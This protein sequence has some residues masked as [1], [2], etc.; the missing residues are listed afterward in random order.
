MIALKLIS[1]HNLSVEEKISAIKEIYKGYPKPLLFTT[2]VG[3]FLKII[4]SPPYSYNMDA[5][6]DL[7]FS[8]IFKGNYAP[9][10]HFMSADYVKKYHQNYIASVKKDG[11]FI[12]ETPLLDISASKIFYF[13]KYPVTEFH[14]PFKLVNC[15]GIMNGYFFHGTFRTLML[16]F[17][18]E[19]T[20]IKLIILSYPGNSKIIKFSKDHFDEWID[21]LNSDNDAITYELHLDRH[22]SPGTYASVSDLVGPEILEL[23]T[24]IPEFHIDWHVKFTG[25]ELIVNNKL[26]AMKSNGRFIVN[27]SVT[28]D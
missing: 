14:F 10:E 17:T 23:N 25:E 22:H 7:I 6:T 21:L 19:D 18:P 9:R 15:P 16:P 4:K 1:L 28:F 3:K 12:D 24:E 5:H 2:T 13:L 26:I 11:G 8:N 20:K 27:N